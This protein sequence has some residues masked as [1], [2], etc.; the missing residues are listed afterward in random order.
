MCFNILSFLSFFKLISR[1]LGGC[2]D[3]MKLKTAQLTKLLKERS[4]YSFSPSL[5]TPTHKHEHKNTHMLYF[6]QAWDTEHSFS[7]PQRIKYF[8][9]FG[10]FLKFRSINA[11]RP[12]CT[13]FFVVAVVKWCKI[14]WAIMTCQSIK[15]PVWVQKRQTTRQKLLFKEDKLSALNK[16]TLALIVPQYSRLNWFYT[17]SIWLHN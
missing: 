10:C 3:H 6:V 4:Q 9:L 15:S 16:E 12:F 17:S 1:V 7:S 13:V 8:E 5:C 2:F 14:R 11:V